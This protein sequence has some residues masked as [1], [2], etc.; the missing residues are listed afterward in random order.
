MELCRFR[1]DLI[2]AAG[3]GNALPVVVVDTNTAVA[4]KRFPG[5]HVD[6]RGMDWYEGEV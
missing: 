6:M 2:E 1:V 3:A 4:L 5:W